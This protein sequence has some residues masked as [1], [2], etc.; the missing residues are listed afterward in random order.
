MIDSTSLPP[1]Y[2]LLADDEGFRELIELYVAEMPGRI[3]RLKNC[4]DA[5]NWGELQ[6][7]A[8]QIK[9]AGG[10][11]G[12]PAISSAGGAVER[13]IVNKQPEEQVRTAT[14]EL[15][16]LCLSVRA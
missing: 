2:S 12:F 9:G 4:L 8:H 5:A 14:L 13:L 11:Y 10:S 6:R 7:V 16:Q 15:I 1:L 3:E